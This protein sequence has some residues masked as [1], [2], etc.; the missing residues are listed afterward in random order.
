MVLLGFVLACAEPDDAALGGAAGRA[1]G[2]SMQHAGAG[3]AAPG[4]AGP[5]AAGAGVPYVQ[6]D[7][8]SAGQP[9]GSKEASA[10]GRGLEPAQGSAKWTV[11]IYGHAD[12]NL[13]PGLRRD[14]EEM[15]AA[16][17]S[18]DV[19]VIVFADWDGSQEQSPGRPFP[20]GAHWY[21]VLG[22]GELL[23]LAQEPELNFDEPAVLADTVAAAFEHFPAERRALILW[24][25]GASWSHGF[26]C[27]G[28]DGT[29]EACRLLQVDEAVRAIE[30]GLEGASAK[31]L[32]LLA[33]DTC[34]MAGA[35]VTWAV[36]GL[37][38]VYIADAEIDYGDGWDYKAFF[39]FLSR[40]PGLP[41]HELAR[42]EVEQWDAHHREASFSDALLRS[43]VA[44]D[45]GVL[46]ATSDALTAFVEEWQASPSTSAIEL[47][48]AS[49]FALP[50]YKSQL[51]KPQREPELRDL[52]QFLGR[53]STS[54]DRE[55]AAR[56]TAARE[57]LRSAVIASSQGDLRR[58][59][60]Q[61]GVHVELP[62]PAAMSSE[63]M[64]AYRSRAKPWLSTSHWDEG[65]DSY[66]DRAD[67]REPSVVSSVETSADGS[68]TVTF[69][70]ADTD[71]AEAGMYLA[72]LSAD[73]SSLAFFGVLAKNPIEADET[74]QYAWARQVPVIL[75]GQGNAQAVDVGI[76]ED[77]GI[78]PNGAQSLLL[79]A[80]YGVLSAPD[81]QHLAALLFEDGSDE[82][83][84]LALLD[85]P[86]AL[87]LA[88]VVSDF[89]GSTFTPLYETVAIESGAEG[90]LLG[91]PIALDRPG[92][93]LS[94]APAHAGR[95]ALVTMASD[96]YGNTGF[97]V[98][99][100]EVP[101][102]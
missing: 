79:L 38:Q 81:G 12:H 23:E 37:A 41:T 93:A 47:A 73:L 68:A 87:S 55:L 65:L 76:W 35:E 32:D 60:D 36:K 30:L 90:T 6:R 9:G 66:R 50:P 33:F 99:L 96:V 40:N 83:N 67:A 1:G 70:V 28:Q 21:R 29:L 31:G 3:A 8:G 58:L 94:H 101:A 19:N 17:I 42:R 78:D 56:A 82:T 61:L 63:R 39:D 34:L 72:Q 16:A 59:V 13:S 77:T 92:F 97:D 49:Y 51:A 75:D 24:D 85:M 62:L 86:V 44:I 15:A 88:Q 102:E 2:R 5:D 18:D 43:H 91:E 64:Q 98:Q 95:Y 57:R 71:V 100:T 74:Y 80:I 11:L 84:L 46:A 69:S 48:R 10:L 25:H 45:L 53:I 4:G 14:L 27:D 22:N 20:T 26:G 7:A 89:P 52:G 54:A